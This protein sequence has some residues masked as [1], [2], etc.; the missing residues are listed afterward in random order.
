MGERPPPRRILGALPPLEEYDADIII[1]ALNRPEDTIAAITSALNQRGGVFHVTVL[2]QGSAP[3]TL[4][5]LTSTFARARNF[6]L[7]V[8]TE[9]LGVAEGRNVASAL[10][11][12]R[13]II[14][15]DND[16]IF[17]TPWIAARALR[18]FDE[19][20]DLGALGFAILSADGQTPEPG[21]WGYPRRL[22]TKFKDRFD[23]T[24]FVGAGHTIRR[25]TWESI[26]GYDPSLFFTWEEYDFCL[27]AISRGWRIGYDGSLP[28]IHKPAVQGRV[29]WTSQRM[30]YYVRNRLNIARKW[31]ASW[32]SQLPRIGG[33]LI[34]ASRNGCLDAAW[35]GMREAWSEPVPAKRTMPKSGHAYIQQNERRQRGSWFVRLQDEVFSKLGG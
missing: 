8:N 13:I 19:E 1:L 22:I 33:Y 14:G 4:N 21:S 27:S 12:G 6:A 35:S 26:G 16:A 2:D 3:E 10:G 18:R 9:N 7:Y 28:V 32:L 24:T 15:L 25:V 23:T 11:H 29:G 31:G 30:R 5:I 34:K 17:T 20:P